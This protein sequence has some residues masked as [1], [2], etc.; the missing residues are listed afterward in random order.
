MYFLH[1]IQNKEAIDTPID[2]I[3]TKYLPSWPTKKISFQLLPTK[4]F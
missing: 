1:K 3:I 2:K 4:I